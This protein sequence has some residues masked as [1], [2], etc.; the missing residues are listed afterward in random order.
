MDEPLNNIHATCYTTHAFQTKKQFNSLKTIQ[1]YASLS[2]N[3]NKL[4]I[5]FKC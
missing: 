3:S 1:K 5:C 4:M 2:I